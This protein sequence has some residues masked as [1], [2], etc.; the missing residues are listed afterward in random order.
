[1]AEVALRPATLDDASFVADVATAVTPTRP[2]DPVIER[3]EWEQ[4]WRN[5]VVRRW[6]VL[7]D[8]RPSGYAL[9]SHPR[10]DLVE[11][12]YGSVV[13]DLLPAE[14]TRLHL[15]RALAE[16]EQASMADGARI[17]RTR[18][19]EDDPLKIE[20]I[21]GRGYHEDRRGRR[22]ELDLVAERQ[23]IV[24][25]TERTRAEM[26]HQGV[27]L[28]TLADDPDPEKHVKVWR[29]SEEA[30]LDVPTTAPHVPE[31][32]EDHMR[33]VT[34]PGMRED[35]FWIARIGDEI[36]GC[37]VLSYPPARGLVGTEWTATAR[38]VRGRGIA[39]AVKCETLAQAIALGVTRV[40]TGN[41]AANDPILHINESMGYRPAV[42][43]TDFL[44]PA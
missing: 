34:G 9:H 2:A 17:L 39:R 23:R 12:R 32:F 31:P 16:M 25:M 33:W 36:V 37:S 10:W 13:A 14:R 35:R 22:W 4:L 18:A 43:A 42:G 44:K 38:L 40:R 27:R 5:W 7:T 11:E 15:D 24:E 21:L 29:L 3:H 1:M 41:D 20:T 19:N 28:L 8:G 30:T 26:R 6:I